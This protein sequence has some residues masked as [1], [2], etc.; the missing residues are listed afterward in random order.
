MQVFEI[1]IT[2][3]IVGNLAF[4]LVVFI[5]D[6]VTKLGTPVWVLYILAFFLMPSNLPEHYPLGLAA[7]CT[8]LMLV[9]YALSPQGLSEPL[10]QRGFVIIVLWIYATVL[11]RR[12]KDD[13]DEKEEED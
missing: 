11:S 13:E 6:L 7:F 5:L 8:L 4:V 1:R 3:S 12:K 2:P 9:G 10:S